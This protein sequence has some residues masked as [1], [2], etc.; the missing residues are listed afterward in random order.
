ME[1]SRPKTEFDRVSFKIIQVI[2]TK[3]SPNI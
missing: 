2:F 3:F 1:I